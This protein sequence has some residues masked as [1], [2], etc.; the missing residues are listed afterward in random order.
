MRLGNEV[1]ETF[2]GAQ[3]WA[4]SAF[5]LDYTLHSTTESFAFSSVS[6]VL[7]FWIYYGTQ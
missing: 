1:L 6:E 3:I 5:M 2:T 7:S 4:S